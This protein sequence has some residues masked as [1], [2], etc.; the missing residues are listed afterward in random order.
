M[1]RE[2][3]SS[4]E[5]LAKFLDE[6]P[7]K[8]NNPKR[9]MTNEWQGQESMLLVLCTMFFLYIHPDSSAIL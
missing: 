8:K 6:V 1:A 5:Q 4:F 3:Q 7:V 9:H 2:N